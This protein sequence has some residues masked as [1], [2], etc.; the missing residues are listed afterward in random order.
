MN[1]LFGY[2]RVSTVRQGEHGVSLQEQKDGITRYAARN[3]VEI[4]SWF[5]ER[6][7][8]A[9]QGRPV[10]NEMMRRLKKKEADGV[11]IHKIDRSARNFKDWTAIEELADRNIAVHFVNESLDLRSTGSR[12]AADVQAVVAAHYVRN[13]REET[14]KGFYGRLK[15]GIY[16]LAAPIGYLD[17]GGGKPKEIDP[18]QGPLVRKAFELYATGR[19][20]LMTLLEEMTRLGLRNR[21]GNLVSL[22]G[23]ST[24]FNN[25]FY[26]G[27]IRLLKTGETFQGVHE[28]LVTTELFRNVRDVLEGRTN[29]RVR[30]VGHTFRRLLRCRLCGYSLI[31]ERQKGH[32][33]YRCQ[34]KSCPTRCVREETVVEAIQ[35]QVL[36][37]L[38]LSSEEVTAARG[39]LEEL[40]KDWA[41]EHTAQREGLKLNKSQ[42][43][44]RLA[45]LT[46]AFI[47]GNIEKEVFEERKAGLA[48]ERRR[49]E[50]AMRE[51]EADPSRGITRAEEFL[52][53]CKSAEMLYESAND[54][55]KREL[56]ALLTS[57][58]TIEAKQLEFTWAS[59][60][61]LVAKRN[62]ITASRLERD[63]PRTWRTLLHELVA[64]FRE[65]PGMTISVK[66]TR[67][68]E[69]AKEED[70]VA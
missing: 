30:K 52:E 53:L 4:A 55:E 15:Q 37:P 50:E 9:K 62:P 54:E 66:G 7:T 22:N 65:H 49:L 27:L 41:K 8:A 33:Y 63:E 19:Y 64:W 36:P 10:F 48:L 60:F 2:I 69:D 56:L 23:L 5:E 11:I 21:R 6:E 67:T 31:A 51:S 25:P 18:V 12:L 34:T 47:D 38:R 32:V 28:P 17:R 45:R 35:T 24:V 13:L 70:L 68:W 26:V 59:P 16:P 57:N 43:S 29:L 61:D 1:R 46:D 42:L 40:K 14:K 58:R 39:I 3:G 20:T 44:A